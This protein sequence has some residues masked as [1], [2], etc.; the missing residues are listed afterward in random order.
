V[1]F[2]ANVGDNAVRERGRYRGRQYPRRTRAGTFRERGRKLDR[3]LSFN[4][5]HHICGQPRDLA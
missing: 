1:N 4:L 2:N 3:D 5:R